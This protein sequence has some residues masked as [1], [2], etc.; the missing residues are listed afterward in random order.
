MHVAMLLPT[1]PF[2]TREDIYYAVE[3][4]L[5][6]LDKPR[7]LISVTPYDFPPQL[8][9]ENKGDDIM[10][11]SEPDSYKT[12]TRSQSIEQRYHP[13]GAIYI[14]SIEQYIKTGTFFQQFMYAYIMPIERSF[15]IDYSYQFKIAD[16]MMK[17]VAEN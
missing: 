6:H 5:K 16:M 3:K 4:Y 10:Y 13:N 2:R 1:C 12:T 15:D 11:M 9:L 14:S 8:A 17:L 7:S